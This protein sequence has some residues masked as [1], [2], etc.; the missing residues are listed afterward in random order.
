H[1]PLVVEQAEDEIAAI[2][3]A[4]GASYAGAR[5]AVGTSGGGFALMVEHISL[6]GITET[7]VVI[8]CIQRPGPATGLPTRTEQ[9]DLLF[10][11]HAGHGEFPRIVFAPGDPLEMFYTSITAFNLA[12]KYQ[13]PVIILGDQY[14][15][16]TYRVCPLPDLERISI[17]RHICA[18][19]AHTAE[20]LRY[21][22]TPTG[23]SPRSI[24]GRGPGMVVADSDEHDQAGHLTEDLDKR[25]K[26][27][28]KRLAK[29]NGIK[30]EISGPTVYGDPK[31]E[32]RLVC[33]GSTA[34]IVQ[35]VVDRLSKHK[36]INYVHFNGIWPFPVEAA[37]SALSGARH[38]I[39]VENNAQA[40]LCALLRSEAGITVNDTILKYNGMQFFPEEI[41]ERLHGHDR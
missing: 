6:A 23:I 39:A 14:L 24:P 34:G 41:I 36:S 25:I 18:P 20:Y 37:R 1:M 10:A 19:G 5:S 22:V 29:Y 13:I 11:I 38:L 33:W 27:N 16:D 17:D 26:Q 40:P 35:E 4:I 2:G 21:H 31:A 8:Y 9:G 32:T 15:A 7:P 12:D 3:M 30:Q 28:N